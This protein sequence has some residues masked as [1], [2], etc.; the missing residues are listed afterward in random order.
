M[1]YYYLDRLRWNLGFENPNHAA[2]LIASLLP[3]LWA[4]RSLWAPRRKAAAFLW[5]LLAGGILI[6]GW[7]LLAMTLSRGGLVAAIGGFAFLGWKTFAGG[8]KEWIRASVIAAGIIAAVAFTGLASRTAEGMARPD[9]SIENRFEVWK[10]GLRMLAIA[11]GG[12][13]AGES[14]EFYMHW[15]QPVDSTAGYRTL[16]N[17]YLTWLTEYGLLAG[18]LVLAAALFVLFG[19]RPAA[20]GERSRC[21][22][23]ASQA[24]LISF[25]LAAVFSTTFETGWVWAPPVMALL[26]LGALTAKHGSVARIPLFRRVSFSLLGSA[27]AMLLLWG[28]GAAIESLNP[29]A[30]RIGRDGLI[31]VIPKGAVGGWAILPDEEVA[32]PDYGK[33]LREIAKEGKIKLIAVPSREAIPECQGI[34]AMGERVEE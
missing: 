6:A 20:A 19:L 5:N 33:R 15:L 16:V 34:I 4:V 22:I 24:S 7:W 26:I 32:G 12:V 31:S 28:T 2:A 9:A 10:G 21:W 25:A 13:G 18:F 11:P 1:E 3:F 17:G 27:A 8:K 14:G 23:R 30:I 29:E